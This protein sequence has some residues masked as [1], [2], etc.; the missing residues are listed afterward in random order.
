MKRSV[1]V[2]GIGNIFLSDDGFGVEV[3]NRLLTVSLPPGV[4]VAEFGIRGVHLA[5]ELLEG[6][7]ALVLVDAV[8]MGEVP[9]TLAVIEPERD[10]LSS[11]ADGEGAV[12]DAHSMSP[13][14]VLGT[15]AHLGGTLEQIYVVG[16]Q[17]G[18]LEEGIGLT[19]PVAAAVDGAVDLCAQLVVDIVQ[20]AGKGTSR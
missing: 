17:P 8:P 7:D 9:G 13:D 2:A 15:L 5:Y 12:V 6:Y 10:K 20:P 16:C 18:S 1:L 11:S 14:V 4:R 3:A 19:P